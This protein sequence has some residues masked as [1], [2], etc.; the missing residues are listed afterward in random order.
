MSSF[1]ILSIV[2]FV[3]SVAVIP[4]I[5]W[6]SHKN[7]ILDQPGE[8]KIHSSPVPRIGGLAIFLGFIVS[9]VI[10]VCFWAIAPTVS[11]H[12]G[13][14]TSG[15]VLIFMTGFIDDLRFIRAWYKLVLQIIAGIFVVASGLTIPEIKI[16]SL[17]TLKLG[18]LAYPLTV[19]WVVAFINAINLM[20]GMDGLA[21]GIVIIANFFIM[22]LAHEAGNDFAF[23]ITLILTLSVLGFYIF[24]FP[25]AKI[26]MG[27]GGAYFLGF[28]FATIAL[29][30]L[31]KSSVLTLFLFPFILL[32]VPLGDIL[33]VM[34]KRLRLGYHI[35]VADKNHLHHRLLKLGFNVKGVLAIV[36]SMT[37]ILGI[38]SILLTKVPLDYSLL[39]FSLIF[40]ILFIA[41][42]SI[43]TAEKVIMKVLRQKL[44]THYKKRIQEAKSGVDRG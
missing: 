41:I 29:M 30:G 13:Y 18:L 14:Y 21:S 16:Y 31:K 24:N 23:F 6:F 12:L 5:L 26:F 27:D 40:L 22:L 10:F 3:I 9:Y 17:G 20:D 28:M 32:L 11:F 33:M 44:R 36:Y 8:R 42:Y 43:N 37:F 25:P 19:I 34:I 2:A 7:N 15:M 38:I 39:L 4:L 1:I 35:F